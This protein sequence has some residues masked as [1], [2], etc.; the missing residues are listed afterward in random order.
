MPKLSLI[1]YCTILPGK[2]INVSGG[3]ELRPPKL[4]L[5]APIGRTERA[6]SS[7]GKNMGP[8][9]PH[10]LMPP[11]FLSPLRTRTATRSEERRGCPSTMY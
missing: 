3:S 6:Y 2:H 11:S 1:K 9:R 7:L 4:A 10:H 8:P 5:N